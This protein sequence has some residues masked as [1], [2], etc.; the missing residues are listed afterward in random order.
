MEINNKK[1]TEVAQ[2][3]NNH[4]IKNIDQIINLIQTD[5]S[6]L[7]KAFH[8]FEE[9]MKTDES[10]SSEHQVNKVWDKL[11]GVKTDE[12]K[13]RMQYFIN[14]SNAYEGEDITE[15]VWMGSGDNQHGWN[16]HY[17]YYE[18][19]EWKYLGT[20]FSDYDSWDD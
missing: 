16:Y 11:G 10:F 14:N 2:I 4:R 12:S 19:G 9:I 13:I 7:S 20:K 6:K 8:L 17:A 15:L 1:I 18:D 3:V 5:N